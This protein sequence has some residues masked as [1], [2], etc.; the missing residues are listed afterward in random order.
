MESFQLVTLFALHSSTSEGLLVIP[1]IS[2]P[3]RLRVIRSAFITT[4]LDCPWW[5][6][7]KFHSTRF[8][9]CLENS[10]PSGEDEKCGLLTIIGTKWPHFTQIAFQFMALKWLFGRTT[11]SCCEASRRTARQEE[12][13]EFLCQASDRRICG[14]SKRE[15]F[16]GFNLKPS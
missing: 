12:A 2:F 1:N 16:I 14:E 3:F 10:S 9:I 13:K 5:A 6:K 15:I 11:L 8:I 4:K 7:W